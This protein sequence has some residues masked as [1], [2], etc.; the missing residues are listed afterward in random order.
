[1]DTIKDLKVLLAPVINVN[2]HIIDKALSTRQ[3]YT[4]FILSLFYTSVHLATV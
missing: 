2:K 3:S 1:M 4:Y